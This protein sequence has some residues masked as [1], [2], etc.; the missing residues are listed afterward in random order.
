MIYPDGNRTI[1]LTMV[2]PAVLGGNY[3]KAVT[4]TE[5]VKTE[6]ERKL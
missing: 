6:E 5:E 2:S 1:V 4:T 3:I